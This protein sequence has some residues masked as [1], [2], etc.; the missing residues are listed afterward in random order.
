[1]SLGPP[2]ALPLVLTIDVGT[3]S[4]RCALH[5]GTGQRLHGASSGYVPRLGADGAVELDPESMIALV[6]ALIDRTMIEAGAL[7]SSIACVASGGFW[8]SMV[9]VDRAGSALTPVYLWR[10]ARSHHD[11]ALLRRAL[12]ERA[13]HARTG[14]V[15]HW[16]YLPA[17]LA[18]IRRTDRALFDRVD[19][20]LSLPD[21]VLERFFG[22]GPTS[23]S[24][25]SATGLFDQHRL[26][27]DDEILA[28]VGL[29]RSHL[30][31]I[32]EDAIWRTGARPEL[33]RLWPEL[34]A[35]PWLPPRGDGAL[36]SI[37]A[38]CATRERAALMVG[39]SVAIRVLFR[40]PDLLIPWGVWGYRADAQRACLGGALNDGGGLVAWMW[41]T[42]RLPEGAALEAALAVQEP[43]AHGL[44]VL[45]LWGGER[46]P[47]WASRAHGAIAG[48]GMH[49]TA[50]DILR[51]TLESIAVRCAEVDAQLRIAV[52]EIRETVATGAALLSSPTWQQNMADAL[53]RPLIASEE[54]EASS[55]GAALVALELVGA[56]PGG[57]EAAP[58]PGGRVV[59]PDPARHARYVE[60]RARQRELYRRE[61]ERAGADDRAGT[62]G[63]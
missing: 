50:L 3:S 26:D 29:E 59:E 4:A 1:M 28:A 18:W 25:A 38:G 40:T 41:R 43:C 47:G 57:V 12:D 24:M 11:A 35:V 6:S 39:T 51:A 42:L 8:H 54:R 22:P 34:A 44:D 55:R 36:S 19:R 52:P 62:G 53:G 23:I 63:P 17:K 20:W 7:R 10:D 14:C 31:P 56:L 60:A 37:G 15:I 32:A 61:I 30:P 5:D 2:P 9:G 45:P 58:R 46:S 21:L 48:L 16:S 27:W 49:T 33:A 13:V